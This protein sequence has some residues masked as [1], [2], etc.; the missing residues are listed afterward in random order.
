MPHRIPGF[1][2]A[3]ERFQGATFVLVLTGA[4]VS[5]ESGVPT[6]RGAGGYWRTRHFS[7]LATRDAFD[8]DA[9]LV[10]DWYL[11]RRTSVRLCRPNAAHL[12]LAQWAQRVRAPGGQEGLLVTQNVD[13]LHE[14]AGHDPTVRLHGSLWRNACSACGAERDDAALAYAELPRC[15]GCGALERPGV[16]W[17]GEA[18]PAGAA[19]SATEAARR[20]DC[21]LVIG[22]A[23]L[24]HP[25]AGLV[26]TA[27]DRGAAIVE[28]NPDED[29][30]VGE[31]GCFGG[32]WLR[33][34]AGTVVPALVAA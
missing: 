20:A 33:A 3:R 19:A 2:P 10:W 31:H 8:R 30:G 5:A 16:V 29:Y 14:R 15:A 26:E 22:T 6:F 32:S 7:E 21:V 12:A 23:G 34:P 11:E 13:G 1:A 17:F 4:G 25:A 27:R 18:I 24:V 9:R 28:V